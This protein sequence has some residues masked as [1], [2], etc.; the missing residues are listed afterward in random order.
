MGL[1]AVL[2]GIILGLPAPL[3]IFGT[4]RAVIFFPVLSMIF[5]F[6]PNET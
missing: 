6:Y 4:L 5:G 2:I 3:I 1:K